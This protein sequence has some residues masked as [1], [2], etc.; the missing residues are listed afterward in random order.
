MR[1]F[2]IDRFAEFVRGKRAVAIKNVTLAEEVLDEYYPGLPHYPHSLIIEGMAQTGGLLVSELSEFTRKVVLAKVGKATFHR[3]VHPS[4][5]I[6]IEVELQDVQSSGAVAE[7]RA[8]VDES[9]QAEVEI[10]FAFL[11]ARFGE[12]PHFPPEYLMRWLRI[13]RLYEVAVDTDGH[14]LS[15]PPFLLEAE[16]NSASV[17]DSAKE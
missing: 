7:C 6:R 8:L 9:V 15:P 4:E 5:Q 11:D 2:W 17:S 13:L 3:L 16:K 1:W 10:W 14:P 12:K